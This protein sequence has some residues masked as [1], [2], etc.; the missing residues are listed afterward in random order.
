MVIL[1]ALPNRWLDS[2]LYSVM[3]HGVSLIDAMNDVSRSLASSGAADNA[4]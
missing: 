1:E 2:L 4:N 3:P